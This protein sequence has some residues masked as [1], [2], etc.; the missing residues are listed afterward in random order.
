MR[1][2]KPF[3]YPGHTRVVLKRDQLPLLEPNFQYETTITINLGSTHTATASFNF[4]FP[5][6]NYDPN[7]GQEID[8]KMSDR[9]DSWPLASPSPAADCPETYMGT[10][11]QTL[12]NGDTMTLDMGDY[13]DDYG[14]TYQALVTTTDAEGEEQTS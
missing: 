1:Y 9:C 4:T 7:T 11:D 5:G 14:L 13:F 3:F 10:Y 6:I 2:L 12:G 8:T